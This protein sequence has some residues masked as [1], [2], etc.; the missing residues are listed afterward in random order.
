MTEESGQNRPEWITRGMHYSEMECGGRHL[1]I[2]V[3]ADIRHGSI[4]IGD[5][6]DEE[7]NQGGQALLLAE[8]RE[9]MKAT[10]SR[11]GLFGENC[12]IGGGYAHEEIL[13]RV[14][15]MRE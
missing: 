12:G 9:R 13:W 5:Q 3:Q 8:Q 14:I 11:R 10:I 2:V 7:A 1:T 6:S 4:P 15:K